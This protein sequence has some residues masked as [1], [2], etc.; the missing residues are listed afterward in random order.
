[1]KKGFVHTGKRITEF[2]VGDVFVS[3]NHSQ[4]IVVQPIWEPFMIDPITHR[5]KYSE[6]KIYGIVGNRGFLI[7]YSNHTELFTHDEM[8]EY[9]N[10]CELK[11]KGNINKHVRTAIKKMT[12]VHFCP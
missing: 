1:M 8:I 10:N 7:P 3:R 9:L 2:D 12:G 6:K 4:I 5:L 11:F